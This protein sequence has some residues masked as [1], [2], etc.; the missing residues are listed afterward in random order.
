MYFSLRCNRFP[1][2]QPRF[3]FRMRS[4]RLRSSPCGIVWPASSPLQST[5]WS[6]LQ[7]ESQVRVTIIE[8]TRIQR[9]IIGCANEYLM[10]CKDFRKGEHL[11]LER[12]SY[13]I[14]VFLRKKNLNWYADHKWIFYKWYIFSVIN[15]IR[16]K[17]S[18]SEVN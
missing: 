16:L 9:T 6:S 14:V 1:F 7:N 18:V 4:L 17:F 3:N 15:W 2:L 13:Y 11:G 8:V 12:N 10:F 5:V